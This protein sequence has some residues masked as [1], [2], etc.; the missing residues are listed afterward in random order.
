MNVSALSLR[1]L[2]YVVAVAEHG[3]FGR[4]A[5]ACHV[6]QPALSAQIRKIEG[7]LELQL[8]ERDNRSVRITPAG[9]AVATQA[10][11]VLE[12]AKKIAELAGSRKGP[13]EGRLRLGAIASVGPYLIPHLLRPLRRRYPSLELVLKE[14]LTETLVAE[15]RAGALDAIIASPTFDEEGL[16]GIPL[17][18]EPFVLA[19][20]KELPLS[21]KSPL[22]TADLKA[23]EMVLLEDGH[24]LKD[25]TLRFCPAGRRGDSRR[26]HATSLE[27]LRHMVAS[28]I[29]YTLLPLLAAQEDPK[30]RGLVVYRRFEAKQVGRIITLYC[31]ARYPRAA[32]I[33]AL[34]ELVRSCLPDGLSP[35]REA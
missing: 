16:R 18:F 17:F 6:S 8:F 19:V 34:A 4:A 15:L 5:E 22:R 21:S 10:R 29:G 32:D 33:D 12:E 7:L 23:E 2:E 35:A 30:L 20:P 3:H 24:C 13:L 25:Q 28:G 26:F 14:G 31:R 11:V 27:T 1:D 9:S